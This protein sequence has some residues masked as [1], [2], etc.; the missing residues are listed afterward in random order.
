M[1]QRTTVARPTRRT[2]LAA[3]AWSVPTIAVAAAAPAYAAS[4]TRAL[5]YST[6]P[7]AEITTVGTTKHFHGTLA[8][9]NPNGFATSGLQIVVGLPSAYSTAA[10]TP[11]VIN[12]GAAGWTT[13]LAGVTGGVYTYTFTA[14]TQL[15]GEATA[16][17]SF[18]TDLL[19]TL[20]SALPP[21]TVTASASNM[22]QVSASAAPKFVS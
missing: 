3:S 2:L 17:V 4:A 10:P 7:T 11:L 21:I 8:V 20:P 9:M 12:G 19:G 16:H 14:T 15:A 13:P 5:T 1:H 6:V 18:D 22:K